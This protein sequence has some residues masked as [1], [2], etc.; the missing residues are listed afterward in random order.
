MQFIS[1]SKVEV[2][3]AHIEHAAFSTFLIL[4]EKSAEFGI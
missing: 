4:E 3:K 2:Y 1:D